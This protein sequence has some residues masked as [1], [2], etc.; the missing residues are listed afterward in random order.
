MRFELGQLIDERYEVLH[1]L[2]AGGMGQVYVVRHRYLDRREALKVLVPDLNTSPEIIERFVREAKAASSLHHE[3][4]IDVHDFAV[5]ADGSPYYTMESLEGEDLGRTLAREGRLP[6]PRVRHVLLQVCAAIAAAHA[7]G[8]VHRDLKPANLY[9]ITRGADPDFIKVLDF[10]I[11]KFLAATTITGEGMGPGSP[12]YM[13]PEQVQAQPLDGRVD[14]YAI[15][16]VLYELLS[17]T[18]PLEADSVWALIDAIKHTEPRPLREVAPHVSPAVEA[19]VARAMAKDRDRRYPTIGALAAA[20]ESIDVMEAI[21]ADPARASA[22]RRPSVDPR[23]ET[24]APSASELRATDEDARTRMYYRGPSAG[25]PGM[26]PTLVGVGLPPT[27]P[28]RPA[29]AKQAPAKLAPAKPRPRVRPRRPR[30]PGRERW[31]VVT[32]VTLALATLGLAAHLLTRS[33][34]QPAA[35]PDGPKSPDPELNPNVRLDFPAAADHD[36]TTGARPD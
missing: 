7:K 2:G 4:I 5:L 22:G 20:I 26:D 35:S 10:G 13:A 6:W 21:E 9:R 16:V 18:L 19:V 27:A 8:I 36:A 17:G 11:A 1:V 15:G 12:Y 33:P 25:A 32:V 34:P 28:R 29:T 3:N 31:I 23:A 14:V 30:E 24:S